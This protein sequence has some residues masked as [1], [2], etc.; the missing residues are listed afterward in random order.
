MSE[1]KSDTARLGKGRR[2]GEKGY[3][4]AKSLSILVGSQSI[5]NV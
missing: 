4:L 5:D 2:E 3:H 1:L